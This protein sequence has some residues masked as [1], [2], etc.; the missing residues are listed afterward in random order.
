MYGLA[1]GHEPHTGYGYEARVVCATRLLGS[2]R[3]LIMAAGHELHAKG[4]CGVQ[5]TCVAQLWG[6]NHMRN[7]TMGRTA[8]GTRLRGANLL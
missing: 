7:M 2:N 4:E 3:V 1:F 8:C 5:T 6:V